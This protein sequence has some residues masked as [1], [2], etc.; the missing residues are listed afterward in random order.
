VRSRQLDHRV[1]ALKAMFVSKFSS[2]LLFVSCSMLIVGVSSNQVDVSVQVSGQS[3]FTQPLDFSSSSSS[4]SFTYSVG[5]DSEVVPSGC[6]ASLINISPLYIKGTCISPKPRSDDTECSDEDYAAD[7]PSEGEGSQVSVNDESAACNKAA[8]DDTTGVM[9][10]QSASG[11][12]VVVD[13][14]YIYCG[15]SSVG[16]L[17]VQNN[18]PES[19][20]TV[21]LMLSVTYSTLTDSCYSEYI[22]YPYANSTNPYERHNSSWSRYGIHG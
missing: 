6:D 7:G 8:G 20:G 13:S 15:I 1:F 10:L 16:F 4:P 18:C 19:T 17:Y 12:G 3:C 11:V 21:S 2:L 22:D 14:G 9:T 5:V